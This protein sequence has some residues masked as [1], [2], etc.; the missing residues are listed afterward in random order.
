M[1]DL[2]ENYKEVKLQL[3]T[4]CESYDHE[5]VRLKKKCEELEQ[6][7]GYINSHVSLPQKRYLDFILIT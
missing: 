1:T 5:V 6:V 7:S 2:I 4:K 3:E